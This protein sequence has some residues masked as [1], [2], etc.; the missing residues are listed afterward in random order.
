MTKSEKPGTPES[1]R[2]GRDISETARRLRAAE[3]KELEEL[4]GWRWHP[5]ELGDF[6]HRTRHLPEPEGGWRQSL[7]SMINAGKVAAL[8]VLEGSGRKIIRDHLDRSIEMLR[9]IARITCG[10]LRES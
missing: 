5:T 10:S 9:E 6:Y 2:P 3:C 8:P 1:S 4:T 7:V